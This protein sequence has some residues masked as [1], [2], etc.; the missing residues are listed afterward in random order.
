MRRRHLLATSAALSVPFMEPIVTQL[1]PNTQ[2][3]ALNSVS[4]T[5]KSLK[6]SPRMPVMFIGHGSPMNAIED[7]VYRRSWQALG[8]EFEG[9]GGA[10]Q[11]VK[12]PV[13]QLILCISAHWITRG[14]HVTGMA[15]PKTIH[16][17]GGFPDQLFAQQYPAPGAPETA[18]EL[19]AMLKSPIPGS[20]V[21]VDNAEWGLDHGTWSV[22]KPMFPAANIPV[23]QLSMDYS[24]APSEHYALGQQLKTLRDYGVLIVGSG[25]IVHNLRAMRQSAPYDW[26][27]E[28]DATIAKQLAS[29]NLAQLADFQKLGEIAKLAHP[30]Y[31]HYLPLLYAAGAAEGTDLLRTFND[32]LTMGSLSMRSTIWS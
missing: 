4:N 14:W 10:N 6:K 26:N 23:M 9:Q 31:D 16:D 8:K 22:I 28:F 25:N 19:S 30:T 21:G 11:P 1:T 13:P 2:A 5:F 20:I 27:I 18:K 3:A 29:G 17:F 12:W 24:R 32:T 15:K 7:N